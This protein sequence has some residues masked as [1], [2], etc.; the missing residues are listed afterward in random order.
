MNQLFREEIF[1]GILDEFQKKTKKV[2]YDSIDP[3]ISAIFGGM[4]GFDGEILTEINFMHQYDEGEEEVLQIFS[5]LTDHIKEERFAEIENRL[6]E[7]NQKCM[8][9]N[10]MLFRKQG[11]ISYRYALPLNVKDA[12]YS[13]ELFKMVWNELYHTMDYFFAYLMVI[14]NEEGFL[15]LEQYMES[16]ED[17]G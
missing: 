12:A 15:P 11:Q 14:S 2:M 6:N 3:S 5:T 17:E 13:M 4:G 16:L 1:H 9:G 8:F 10:F 7:L